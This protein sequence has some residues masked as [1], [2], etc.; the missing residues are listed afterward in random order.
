MDNYSFKGIPERE[1][2]DILKNCI[3]ENRNGLFGLRYE[4]GK[5][6]FIEQTHYLWIDPYGGLFLHCWVVV[7]TSSGSTAWMDVNSEVLHSIG[8]NR[9]A[10]EKRLMEL[11]NGSMGS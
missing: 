3:L 5:G 9:E 11:K 4:V 7:N 1:F 10:Y 6:S 8:G 2:Q